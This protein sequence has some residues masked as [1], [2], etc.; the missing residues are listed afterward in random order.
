[1]KLTVR[2][3]RPHR[4]PTVPLWCKFWCNSL[5]H[6]IQFCRCLMNMTARPG[7]IGTAQFSETSSHRSL[8]Q[9]CPL[10]F[11]RPTVDHSN[12]VDVNLPR[13]TGS[14]VVAIAKAHGHFLDRSH[15]QALGSELR[16]RD[17]RNSMPQWG[18]YVFACG[19]EALLRHF[20]NVTTSAWPSFRCRPSHCNNLICRNIWYGDS[21]T[22]EKR[23]DNLDRPML[24]K[25]EVENGIV[26]AQ[27]AVVASGLTKAQ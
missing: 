16:Q 2:Q 22:V 6:V 8:G 18:L 13:S 26:L 17:S 27:V 3:P 23:D 25:A 9:S 24:P 7:A 19:Q 4:R 21:R 15:V 20:V 5:A 1:M 11:L 14:G 10:T 12:I